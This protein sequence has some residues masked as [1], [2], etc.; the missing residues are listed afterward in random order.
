MRSKR[1]PKKLGFIR[2]EIDIEMTEAMSETS[3]TIKQAQ[4]K[5]GS[6]P[7]IFCDAETHPSKA[8]S[9]P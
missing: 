7:L 6:R 9:R 8:V 3:M 4:E 5:R 2:I 1:D